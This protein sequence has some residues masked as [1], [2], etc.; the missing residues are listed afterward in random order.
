MEREGER[1]EGLDTPSNQGTQATPKKKRKT[2]K[3]L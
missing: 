3:G 1:G 2:I